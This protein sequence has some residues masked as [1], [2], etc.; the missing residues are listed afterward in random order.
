MAYNDARGF[1]T[2][3][4]LSVAPSMTVPVLVAE[5]LCGVDP[6]RRA[7]GTGG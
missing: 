3:H 4:Y 1:Q 2:I 7:P 5:K 6:E